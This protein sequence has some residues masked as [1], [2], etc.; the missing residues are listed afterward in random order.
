MKISDLY[1]SKFIKADDIG[2]QRLQL[3]IM[4][5]T[6]E[7]IADNERKPVLRFLRH[8]KGMILNKTNAT[9]LAGAF[10]DDSVMWQG[11]D[12][13]LMAMPTLFQG[14][15]VMG[16]V[17]LP[18]AGQPV[19][20][21]LAQEAAAQQQ[22]QPPT[23]APYNQPQ[24]YQQQDQQQR[25]TFGDPERPTFTREQFDALK[26]SEEGP[27]IQKGQAQQQ[28]EDTAADI[29]KAEQAIKGQLDPDVPIPF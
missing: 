20:G 6:V 11:R 18:M 13:E 7:E 2:N 25:G 23:Q 3:Q 15:Q 5:L 26:A 27:A 22:W 4:S 24:T 19:P 29:E 16:L 21:G 10:G 12:V 14:K 9:A 8:E 28:M 17:L 1:P